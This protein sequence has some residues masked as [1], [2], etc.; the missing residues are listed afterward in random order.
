MFVVFKKYKMKKVYLVHGWGGNNSSEGWFGWLKGEMKKRKV[1][2]IGFDMPDTDKPEIEKWVGFLEK[3]VK[4][5]DINEETYFIGHSIGCQTILRFL[6][7]QDKKIAGCVFVAGW[8]NLKDLEENEIEI[9][10]PWLTR[11][12]D[13]NKARKNCKKFLAIFS[14]DD[15]YVP[16]SDAEIFKKNLGARII[17]K[18]NKEHFN[19]VSRIDEI[20]DFVVPKN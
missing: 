9:A 14:D 2:L 13:F 4:I 5:D 19:N 15:P 17:I 11:K 7:K 18:H 3:N 6:E 10:K 12:I 1:E 16:V 8:F 20:L